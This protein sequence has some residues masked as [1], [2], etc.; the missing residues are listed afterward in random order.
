[1]LHST[2]EEI[3]CKGE[4]I[5]RLVL[6]KVVGDNERQWNWWAGDSDAIQRCRRYRLWHGA[7]ERVRHECSV[8]FA[9]SL[10]K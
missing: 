10:V 9:G 4:W 1:M 3:G 8:F 6:A 5:E 7:I 2:Q